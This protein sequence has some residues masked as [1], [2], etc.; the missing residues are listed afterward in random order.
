MIEK[1]LLIFCLMALSIFGF[2]LLIVNNQNVELE[3]RIIA[4]EIKLDTQCSMIIE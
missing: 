2:G 3:K 1:G 4:L